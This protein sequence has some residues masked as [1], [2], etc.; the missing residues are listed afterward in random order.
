MDSF[1]SMICNVNL[2]CKIIVLSTKQINY[3]ELFLLI[4]AVLY[5]FGDVAIKYVAW[6]QYLP[7]KKGNG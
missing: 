1:D 4:N 2:S 6:P 5:G 3:R 7:V